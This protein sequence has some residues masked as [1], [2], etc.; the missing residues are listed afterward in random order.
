MS[1]E[2]SF[3]TS[4]VLGEFIRRDEGHHTADPAVEVA[5]V[6]Q[7]PLQLVRVKKFRFAISGLNKRTIRG[8][9]YKQKLNISEI[10]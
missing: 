9:L 7:E 4:H 2:Q 10:L 6:T 1:L 8:L 5:V 3:S